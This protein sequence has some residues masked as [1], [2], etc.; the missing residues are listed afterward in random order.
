MDHLAKA[1]HQLK[2]KNIKVLNNY[3]LIFLNDHS[4]V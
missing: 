3:K 4:N 1:I 2:L